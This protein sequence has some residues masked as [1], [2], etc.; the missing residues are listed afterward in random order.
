MLVSTAGIPNPDRN[1][2]VRVAGSPIP[3]ESLRTYFKCDP[4]SSW[5]AYV[6]GCL[7]VLAHEKGATFTDGIS[8]LVA[9]D[10][11]EGGSLAQLRPLW[12]SLVCCCN[13]L[14]ARV[15]G[16]LSV[17]CPYLRLPAVSRLVAPAQCV[18]CA[19]TDNTRQTKVA[20]GCDASRL[21]VNHAWDCLC[22]LRA[23]AGKGVS[24][25]AAL[26][27]SVMSAVAAAHDIQ[28]G[29][30]EL[31]LL[32]QKVEVSC[33]LSAECVYVCVP[34]PVQF[35]T[36]LCHRV[37]IVVLLPALAGFQTHTR[38]AVVLCCSRGCRTCAWALPVASWTR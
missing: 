13:C 8:I 36:I 27:V 37:Q 5:G 23:A 2:L 10:V 14:A 35:A 38:S 34:G 11:P 1:M 19:V 32:C 21:M 7:L 26:E 3:Y 16:P 18:V 15:Q 30:R 4:A 12:L 28:L 17:S 22:V 9:S 33:L 6:A 31:A 24:S 29:G 25:S 20:C